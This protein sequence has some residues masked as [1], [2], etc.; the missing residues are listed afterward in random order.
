MATIEKRI[1]ANGKASFRVKVRLRGYPPQSASF[2]RRTDAKKWA[3]QTEA[4]I[5]ENRYFK[6]SE[7]RKHTLNDLIDRFIE[8][9]L[10]RMPKVAKLFETQLRWWASRIGHYT[11]AD[12]TPALIVQFREKLFREGTQTKREI[13][14]ATVNRYV[15]ALSVAFSTASRDWEWIEDSPTRKVRRLQEPRG[16]ARILSDDE[17]RGLLAACERSTNQSLHTIVVLALSTGA[18]KM[19]LLGLRWKDVDLKRKIITFHD[20]KNQ[21]R[22]S[23]PLQGLAYHLVESHSKVRRLDSDL[24][25]PSTRNPTK[26]I[27]IQDPWQKALK[28]AHVDD[29]RFHDLR[30][31]A[32]SYLAMSGATLAEIAHVL[33]HKTLQ[34]VQRYAHLTEAHTSKVVSRMNSQIFGKA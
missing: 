30:H 32:A 21:E 4:A 11:L 20:T 2:E 33:G 24:L 29:F 31:S 13:S 16:R 26:P 14:A 12:V 27:A 34:M 22:R 7:A 28:E 19:E 1:L 15:A 17:R 10:P 23:V 18:R 5:R 9:E 3:Q 8:F 25:F 6:T